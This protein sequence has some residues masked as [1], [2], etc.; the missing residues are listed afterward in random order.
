MQK[1][2]T[3][4]GSPSRREH[5]S[6]TGQLAEQHMRRIQVAIPD[7]SHISGSESQAEWVEPACFPWIFQTERS[8]V[9]QHGIAGWSP[10][11]LRVIEHQIENHGD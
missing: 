7:T 3:P 6:D 11:N 9:F 10:V 8:G 2:R 5:S 4:G 1:R